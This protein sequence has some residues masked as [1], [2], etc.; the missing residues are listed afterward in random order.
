MKRRTVTAIAII[1]VGA[2]AL[3][4]AITCLPL[5]AWLTAMVDWV[6]HA[7]ALGLAVYLV[8]FTAVSLSL[9]PTSPLYLAAGVLYGALWGTVVMVGFSIVAAL[10]TFA[11]ARTVLRGWV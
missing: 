6:R 1:A 11:L 10:A 9:I 2:A 4:L 5:M 8:V 7:G 3:V